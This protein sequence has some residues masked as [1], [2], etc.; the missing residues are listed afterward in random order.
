MANAIV[1]VPPPRNEPVLTYAPGTPERR[2]LGDTLTRTASQT[3]DITPRI[4]G[5]RVETGKLAHAV[6]PHRHAHTLATWHAA[7]A[8]EVERA[9]DAALTAHAG[10]SRKAWEDRAALFLRAAELLAGPWRMRLNA[11]TM[12]GQ[13]KTAFQAEID[14][15][16]ELID[17]WRFNPFY[18]QQLYDQQPLSDKTMWN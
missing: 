6:M 16:C 1:S 4:G 13:S 9:I 10:W 5:L 18:A 7:G 8:A 15:A 14:S 3:I 2:A 12:L 11:V 17:F